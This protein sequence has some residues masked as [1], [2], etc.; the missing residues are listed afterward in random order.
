[1]PFAFGGCEDGCV[2]NSLRKSSA[3][4]TCSPRTPLPEQNQLLG[5]SPSSQP[6][7]LR[8]GLSVLLMEGTTE[9]CWAALGRPGP[10]CSR[11]DLKTG[12]AG[13][14]S[15]ALGQSPGHVLSVRVASGRADFAVLSDPEGASQA[16]HPLLLGLESG[17][18]LREGATCRDLQVPQQRAARE[19]PRPHSPQGPGPTPRGSYLGPAHPCRRTNGVS[20]VPAAEPPQGWA[21]NQSRGSG[22]RR[23]LPELLWLEEHC[24]CKNKEDGKGTGKHKNVLPAKRDAE[25]RTGSPLVLG[26]RPLVCK[27]PPSSAQTG[28][29]AVQP[30]HTTLALL[31]TSVIEGSERDL[32]LQNQLL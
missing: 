31:E 24:V 1:M 16:P 6:W 12:C 25:T 29:A 14:P 15:K 2:L 7:G 23:G 20:W 13:T 32:F 27:F 19:G 4:G 30:A 28:E 18:P 3:P 17:D 8:V 5:C 9:G 21:S 22:L 11:K 26:P 10:H